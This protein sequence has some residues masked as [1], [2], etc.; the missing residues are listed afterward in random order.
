[1][2]LELHPSKRINSISKDSKDPVV[3]ILQTKVK[4]ELSLE[5]LCYRINQS[6]TLTEADVMACISQLNHQIWDA[7]Q[8]GYKVNLGHL[9]SFKMAVQSTSKP[10]PSDLRKSDVQKLKIN[11]QP[12]QRLKQQLRSGVELKIVH[13]K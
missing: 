8:Q 11:Y 7:L 5:D 3:Y 6:C 4:A 12:S 2:P 1:M 9:G 13:K 10:L